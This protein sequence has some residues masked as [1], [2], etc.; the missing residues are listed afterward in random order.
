LQSARHRLQRT[1]I[2]SGGRREVGP[3]Q[4]HVGAGA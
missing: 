3:L 4:G 1:W 2:G